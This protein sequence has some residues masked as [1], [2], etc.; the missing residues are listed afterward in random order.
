MAGARDTDLEAVAARL[1]AMSVAN[2]S[3][4][5]SFAATVTFRA[6]RYR[7]VQRRL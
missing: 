3:V 5:S 6:A 7:A 1:K 2:P 4:T